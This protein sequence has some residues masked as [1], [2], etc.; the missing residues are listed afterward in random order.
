MMPA[1]TPVDLDRLTTI[2]AA[3]A[4]GLSP[5]LALA[6]IVAGGALVL[7]VS[8]D[9]AV[10]DMARQVIGALA[11]TI[12]ALVAAHGLGTLVGLALVGA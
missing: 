1:A 9:A 11:G 6:A 4:V 7:A 12:G 10:C 5:L 2:L 8:D 3:T